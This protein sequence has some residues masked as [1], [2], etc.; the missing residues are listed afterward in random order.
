MSTT[1]ADTHEDQDDPSTP[2][3]TETEPTLVDETEASKD[4]AG[5]TSPRP[6]DEFWLEDGNLTLIAGDVEFKVY[7]GPLMANSP[8]FRDMLSLPQ[9][10]ELN[11]A[12]GPSSS[13][14]CTCGYAP[15]LVH[16]SDSPEDL[17]HL[18]R[19]LVPGKTPRVA[20][21][22]PT[23]HAIAACV[24]LGHKYEID[25]VVQRSIDYLKKHFVESYDSWA[26]VEPPRPPAF[27]GVHCIGVVNL[28]RMMNADALLPTALMNCCMLDAP[29]LANGFARE[30]GTQEKLSMEDLGRCFLGRAN[31]MQ[32]NTLA[33]LNLFNQALATDC[34]RRDV[35]GP[36][37]LRLLD[38][39]RNHE[40]VV[41]T[42]DWYKYWS[43]YIDNRDDD[44]RLCAPCYKM[45]L[46][47]EKQQHRDIWKKLPEL[48]GITV[49]GWAADLTPAVVQ[50][51]SD[52]T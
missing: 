41:C 36:V 1:A 5:P 7:K 40:K 46:E 6:D 31:L 20:P 19:A 26:R 45:L 52:D 28:A 22:D 29:E 9:P 43:D 37:F 49:E 48:M 34:T 13:I 38:E 47:R 35:C 32:A 18:L 2:N 33:T 11:G 25:H 30:D 23:F 50:V 42:L 17:R 8:V 10:S 3:L 15:A 21:E 12:T 27:Q 14:Q 24:R 16:V 39:L 44:R 51:T 4:L